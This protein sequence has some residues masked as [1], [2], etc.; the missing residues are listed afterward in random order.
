MMVNVGAFTGKTIIDPL[1]KGDGRTS[2]YLHNLFSGAMTVIALLAVIL[3][4]KST[5][6]AG[7]G[8]SLREIGQGFMRL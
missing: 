2:L 8:K 5:H 4:Y 7:E 1:M 3:L 6:T